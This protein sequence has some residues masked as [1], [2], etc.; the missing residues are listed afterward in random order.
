MFRTISEIT[1]ILSQFQAKI[2][3]IFFMQ[4]VNNSKLN[5]QNQT[6]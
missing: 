1:G 3:L 5:F 2:N 4:L 6:F